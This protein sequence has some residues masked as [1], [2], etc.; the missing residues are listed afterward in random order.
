[1]PNPNKREGKEITEKND[2]RKRVKA[3]AAMV[4]LEEENEEIGAPYCPIQDLPALSPT[5]PIFTTEHT[6]ANEG[7]SLN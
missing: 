4:R 6:Q 7:I 5:K 3:S 2:P 1:M